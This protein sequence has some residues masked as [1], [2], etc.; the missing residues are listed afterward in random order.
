MRWDGSMVR[1]LYQQQGLLTTSLSGSQMQSVDKLPILK[2]NVWGF[3]GLS[4]ELLKQEWALHLRPRPWWWWRSL[5]K[6]RQA[7][8]FKIQTHST[9]CSWQ[10]SSLTRLRKRGETTVQGRSN[11][12]EYRLRAWILPHKATLTFLPRT[13]YCPICQK[14]FTRCKSLTSGES[15]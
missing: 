14:T 11:T 10:L 8:E 5:M 13:R 2:S 3:G 9:Q 12:S 15:L 6:C 4:Q 7:R 1:S